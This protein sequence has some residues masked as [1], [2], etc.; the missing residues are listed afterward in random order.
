MM[1]TMAMTYH[2]LT[3]HGLIY[4][5]RVEAARPPA[6]LMRGPPLRRAVSE[7]I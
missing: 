7:K 6:S 3:Y 4:P 5:P 1:V 2:G